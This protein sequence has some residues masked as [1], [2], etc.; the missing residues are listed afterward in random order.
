M[1]VLVTG[2]AGY[3]GSVAVERLLMSGERVVVLDNFSTGHRGALDPRATVVEGDIQNRSLVTRVLQEHEVDTVM[4]F[5]AFIVVPESCSEPLRYFDNNFVGAHSVLSAMQEVGVKQFIF[6]STAAVYGNPVSSPITEDDPKSP[7]NPYGLSKRMIEQ[8]LEWCA[9]AYGMRYVALRYF[10]ACG[11]SEEHGEDHYPESHLIPNILKAAAGELD[12]IT[13]YG[14][15]YDTPDGTCIRDYIHIEDLV[16]AHIRAMAYLRTGNSA[17]EVN[18]GNSI[19]YSVMD[20][21]ESV[22]RVTGR[23]FAVVFKERRP[24]DASALVASSDK[25]R[26]ILGWQP[27]KPEIDTIVRDAWNWKLRHP[28]GYEQD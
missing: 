28:V 9:S 13:V 6:S 5:A 14:N 18:L 26:Q 21:I 15:D 24:G 7:L 22:R 10:N 23:D 19:G 17:I 11:A 8:I 25:A 16:D 4:H 20:V 27:Q 3:I 1:S 12:C 2:G